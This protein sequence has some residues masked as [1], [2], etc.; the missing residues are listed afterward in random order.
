MRVVKVA[1]L[2]TRVLLFVV[3]GGLASIFPPLPVVFFAYLRAPWS[4]PYFLR[5]TPPPLPL[6]CHRG[7]KQAR[8]QS[9]ITCGRDESCLFGGRHD[10]PTL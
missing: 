8:N 9:S 10:D 6:Q 5:P 7:D 2:R 4:L 3:G 1:L